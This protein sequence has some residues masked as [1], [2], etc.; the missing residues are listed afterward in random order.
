MPRI[1][2]FLDGDLWNYPKNLI[3]GEENRVKTCYKEVLK[4]R[5]SIYCPRLYE[6]FKKEMTNYI[7]RLKIKAPSFVNDVMVLAESLTYLADKR[8]AAHLQIYAVRIIY[9]YILR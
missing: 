6:E 3:V 1:F 2:K 5:G 7:P 8:L 9:I 4:E